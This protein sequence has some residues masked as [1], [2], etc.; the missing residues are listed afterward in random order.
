MKKISKL[1][2]PKRK[3][4]WTPTLCL[5]GGVLSLMLFVQIPT[6]QAE[7]TPFW[8]LLSFI[9]PSQDLAS[10]QRIRNLGKAYYEQGKYD[11]AVIQF[12]KITTLD[13]SKAQDHFNLGLA[14]MQNQQ[15]NASLGE[16]NTAHQ[17][18]PDLTAALYNLGIIHK[19]L[20]RYPEAEAFLQKVIEVD[21]ND[22]AAW[23]NLGKVRFDQ[24]KLPEALEAYNRV[25]AMGFGKGQNFYVASLFHTF[26]TLMRLKQ[27]E[28]AMKLFS[29]H[30]SVKDKVPSIALQLPALEGGRYGAILVSP[31]EIEF[32]SKNN[33]TKTLVFNDISEEMNF[34]LPRTSGQLNPPLGIE[35]LNNDEEFSLSAKDIGQLWSPSAVV[36]DVN[37]DTNPDLL[38]VDPT[39]SIQLF[40]NNEG[41]GF[42]DITADSN[43]GNLEGVLSATFAD[44]DNSERTSLLVVGV[45]GLKL[46][47]R[48][49]N[50]R[51]ANITQEAG[52]STHSQ[53]VITSGVFFDSDNDGLLDLF[54]TSFA[55]LTQAPKNKKLRFPQDFP[56]GLNHFYRNNGD[57]T[58]TEQT[59]Q[60]G[61]SLK[62]RRNR[63]VT[64][65]D[66][67]ND[68]YV[69]LIISRDGLQPVIFLG[70]GES[71]FINYIST[72][73]KEVNFPT[74][75]S[76]TTADF[77]HDGNL[78]LLLWTEESPKIYLNDGFGNFSLQQDP[79]GL[80]NSRGSQE[81]G[82]TADV[83]F[84]GSSDLIITDSD[85]TRIL[86]NDSGRGFYSSPHYFQ[87]SNATSLISILS[88]APFRNWSQ[89]NLITLN[90][91]GKVQIYEADGQSGRWLH[92]EL[93]G[94]KSN[95]L[96]VGATIEVKAGSF[97]RKMLVTEGPLRV[98]TGNRDRL[99]VVRLT[100]PNLIIQNR[101]EISS[102]QSLN[103]RESER[104]ASSC[105]FLYVW[106]GKQYIFLTD[107]LGTAPLGEYLPDGST[108][109]PNPEEYVRIPG[110]IMQE[111]KGQYVLQLTNELREVDFFDRI[112]LYAIDHPGEKDV[113]ANER[114]YSPPFS[115]PTLHS[116]DVKYLP[117]LARDH[118]GHS[119]L[120]EITFVDGSYA[121]DFT[122]H[123]IT[124]IAEPHTLT[125]KP[126]KSTPTVGLKLF[127]TGWVLWANSDG[128]RALSANKEVKIAP[129]ALQVKNQSGQW[130]TVIEDLGL[131]SGTNRTMVVD[132]SGIFLSENRSIRL[133]T[134]LCVYWDQVFFSNETM[135][136]QKIIKSELPITSANL[137]YRGFST[138]VSDPLYRKPDDFIYNRL[139]AR[140]PWNPHIGFYT[141]YGDVRKLLDSADDKSIVMSVG[142]ELTVKFNSSNLPM[143]K[144]GWKRDFI[145]HAHGWAKPGEPN[146][147]FGKTVNPMPFLSM[148]SYP[149]G[150]NETPP[151][152]KDYQEY[153]KTYQTRYSTPLIPPL[154]PYRSRPLKYNF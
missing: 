69:D 2:C 137:H 83:N 65:S 35:I 134:N 34:S 146:A 91:E 71:K 47:Q 55:D 7:A 42:S 19:R 70:K 38:F 79:L 132:L 64:I 152:H 95:L 89:V 87:N 18:S 63:S 6:S 90:K 114:Y 105:P 149:Y 22:P 15:L 43:I 16:L 73:S 133:T 144:P 81:R 121:G 56:G 21:P 41:G 58:F 127:L 120:K 50:G 88:A 92:I 46:L 110:N 49:E 141:R 143:L 150:S 103:I 8:N 107:V 29:K 100:W 124:G 153:L 20:L 154:A 84:D 104:L 44:F 85:G 78:D 86:I 54:I 122:R 72:I 96:G 40:Q 48:D 33:K 82:I 31:P 66:L 151:T 12:E 57:G 25:V 23:F 32:F 26:T 97:Y 14:L 108:I 140:A 126:E 80:F 28:K 94:S 17:I 139:L 1:Y 39:G 68:F 135:G 62:R 59:E 45:N 9:S 75:L 102:G 98:F 116:V 77:D 145:L 129:L 10:S 147:G 3:F 130:V 36:K 37:F 52:L 136:G 93:T 118:H 148:S 106:D 128:S 101:I 112:R 13:G 67:N 51:F 125:L 119:L 99:D 117:V 138:P 115:S 109:T 74:A 113:Y 30:Q 11:E 53:E 123:R 142:D 24:R 61:F 76:T 4:P 27:Q 131:P 111:Q 60:A 5:A